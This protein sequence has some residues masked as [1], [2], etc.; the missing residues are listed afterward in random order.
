V[1]GA[2]YQEDGDTL[3][4]FTESVGGDS[5]CSS[6]FFARWGER[7]DLTLLTSVGVRGRYSGQVGNFIINN[8]NLDA[9]LHLQNPTALVQSRGWRIDSL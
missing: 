3:L 5:N 1:R 6:M 8:V 9:V 4:P 7:R 2:G